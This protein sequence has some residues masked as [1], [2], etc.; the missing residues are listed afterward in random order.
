MVYY[1]FLATTP[2]CGTDYEEY[3]AYEEQPTEQELTETANEICLQNAESY[4]YLVTGWNGENIEDMSEDE[5]EEL[6]D[7]YYA[8][9]SC[10]YEKITEEEY[11]EEMGVD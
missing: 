2:Y 10:S 11:N 9:C 4:E 6:L 3:F 8:D 5:T 7:N 1:K